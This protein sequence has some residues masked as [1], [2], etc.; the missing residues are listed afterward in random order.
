MKRKLAQ[1]GTTGHIK[2]QSE[3]PNS[4]PNDMLHVN[5]WCVCQAFRKLSKVLLSLQT[6]ITLLKNF[7][8]VPPDKHPAGKKI[9]GKVLPSR[10]TT[11]WKYTV[12]MRVEGEIHW[13]LVQS[14]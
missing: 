12:C 11:P 5:T 1:Q 14:P 13:F 7:F 9:K 8:I 6:P 4:T 10:N 3:Q 2:S